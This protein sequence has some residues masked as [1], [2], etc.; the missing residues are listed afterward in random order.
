MKRWI[1]LATILFF[2]FLLFRLFVKTSGRYETIDREREWYATQLH[3]DFSAIIDRVIVETE[4]VQFGTITGNLVMGT[5]SPTI[6]DSLGRQLK[7]HQS[8]KLN[9]RK[10]LQ[11]IEIVMYPPMAARNYIVGDSLVVTSS[12]DEIIVFRNGKKVTENKLSE[13]LEARFASMIS[14]DGYW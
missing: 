12:T 8:L 13:A 6:E 9:Q 11:K 14:L 10:N 2:G 4:K 1:I 5:A 7:A 3:Y